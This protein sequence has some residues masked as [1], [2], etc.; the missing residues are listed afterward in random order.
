MALNKIFQSTQSEHR[1]RVVPEGTKSGDPLLIG[2]RP[3]VALTDRGDGT[4]E[5]TGALPVNI[6]SLEY[7]SGGASLQPDQASVAFDGTWEFEVT[8]AAVSTAQDVAVY[9][10]GAGALTLTQG[11]NTLYGHTDYPE[12]YLK[13]A[14]RA[15]VRIGA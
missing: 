15:P 1:A 8:G 6:V 9:I 5:A 13:V 3:A 2:D 12:S 4:R 14:G 11:S 7:K 10:T